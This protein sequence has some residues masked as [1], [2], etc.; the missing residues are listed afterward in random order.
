MCLLK[1]K[2]VLLSPIVDKNHEKIWQFS[3]GNPEKK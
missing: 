2:K 3:A 1:I